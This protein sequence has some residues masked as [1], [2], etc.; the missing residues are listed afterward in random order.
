MKKYYCP[1]CG[2]GSL[3]S[4]RKRNQGARINNYNFCPE[5]KNNVAQKSHWIVHAV[6]AASMLSG[7]LF[8]LLLLFAKQVSIVLLVMMFALFYIYNYGLSPLFSKFVKTEKE[9]LPHTMEVSFLD[10]LKNPWLYFQ[11]TSVVL[12]RATNV[13]VPIRIE[14]DEL[15]GRSAVCRF[16]FINEDAPEMLGKDITLLDND[17]IIGIAKCVK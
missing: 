16:S 10:Q 8:V 11:G 6:F 1:Y 14:V 3:D 4:Y 9:F 12:A 15:Q 13:P 2:A 17:K 5:C 7:I